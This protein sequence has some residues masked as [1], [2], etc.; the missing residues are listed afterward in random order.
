[1]VKPAGFDQSDDSQRLQAN[2]SGCPGLHRQQLV[3]KLLHVT[4]L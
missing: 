2:R 1:M 4:L 3:A